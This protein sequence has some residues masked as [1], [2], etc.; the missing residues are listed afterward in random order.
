MKLQ[1]IT[2]CFLLMT[3][4]WVTA[5]TVTTF[6]GGTPDDAIAL[7]SN[8]NI[9]ASNYVGDAVFKFTPSGDVESF[10]TGLNTPNGLEF[11]SNDELYVCDGQGNT[12]YRYDTSGTEIDAYPIS[13]HPSGILKSPDDESMYFTRY[14]GNTVNKLETDGTITVISDAA[15]LNGPVGLAKDENGTLYVGNYTDRKI[16][17]ILGTGDLEYIAQLPAEGAFPNL[18]FITYAQGKIWGTILGNHKIYC[19]D[20]DNT[21]VYTVFAGSTQGST[22]GDISIATFS[23]PNGIVFNDAQDTMYVTDFGPKNLR[24]ISGITL[25][26]DEVALQESAIQLSPNPALDQLFLEGTLI[27]GTYTVDI[28][29]TTGQLLS[30]LS[31]SAIG[32][33]IS[34][35]LNISN[36]NAGIYFVKIS[37]GNS[38]I[39]KRVI[40]K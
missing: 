36:L 30:Q 39:T 8:G 38:S 10:V 24:I 40:K 5:Q 35:S 21:D 13:G 19:I 12:I 31:I 7:D 6:S 34:E 20:P 27:Q 26:T 3:S 29:N 28:Y 2:L 33:S 37:D 16:F 25:G 9:Y 17:R 15:D 11:N 22:D 18:G 4:F 1:T 23:N 14:V 32:N